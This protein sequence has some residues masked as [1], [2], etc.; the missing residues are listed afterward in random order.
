LLRLYE[1]DIESRLCVA[2][3][4]AVPAATPA[5]FKN[6]ASY[7][8]GGFDNCTLQLGVWKRVADISSFAVY[9]WPN[10]FAFVLSFLAPLWS[11][12]KF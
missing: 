5:E 11:I 10:G 9:G 12:G 1:A 7:A 3:I 8:F 6:P 4:I 2:I